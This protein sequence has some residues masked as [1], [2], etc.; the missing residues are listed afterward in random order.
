MGNQSGYTVTELIICLGFL[1]AIAMLG[2]IIYVA[3]HFI[4]KFW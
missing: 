1:G 2:G 3:C 4:S